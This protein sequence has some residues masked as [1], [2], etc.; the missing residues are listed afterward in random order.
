MHFLYIN[1]AIFYTLNVPKTISK[2]KFKTYFNDKYVCKGVIVNLINQIQ[3][4]QFRIK[5]TYSTKKSFKSS[6]KKN[7]F[8]N[9]DLQ[10]LLSPSLNL[11]IVNSVTMYLVLDLIRIFLK[12]GTNQ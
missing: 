2:Q 6:K 3:E 8:I 4:S 7:G 12:C 11:L 1:A 5:R 10:R 9:L